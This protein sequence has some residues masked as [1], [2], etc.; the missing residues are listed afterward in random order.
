MSIDGA[1]PVGMS[2]ARHFDTDP[3]LIR[4]PGSLK[5]SYLAHISS[6]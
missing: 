5:H 4:L 3:V 2:E 1:A 6:R